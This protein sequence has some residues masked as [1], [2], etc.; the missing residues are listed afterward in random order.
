MCLS[1][2]FSAGQEYLIYD[3]RKGSVIGGR[4]FESP[5]SRTNRK[6]NSVKAPERQHCP[7]KPPQSR[8]EGLLPAIPVFSG[9]AAALALGVL[10]RV[11]AVTV[12]RYNPLMNKQLL[13]PAFVKIMISG[14]GYCCLESYFFY[15]PVSLSQQI[16][17]LYSDHKAMGQS[18]P[19]SK[20]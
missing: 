20:S 2:T 4:L 19:L 7:Q 16:V 1:I 8:R 14:W 13:P 3:F 18:S 5:S 6:N 12:G 17:C 11:T 9:H 15:P 10:F